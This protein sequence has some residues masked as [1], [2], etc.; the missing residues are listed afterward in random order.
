MNTT[1]T[2]LRE[3]I[4]SR[5]TVRRHRGPVLARITIDGGIACLRHGIGCDSITRSDLDALVERGT[6]PHCVVCG[7]RWAR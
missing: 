5:M 6:N 3:R 4:A 1:T 7:R 2:T